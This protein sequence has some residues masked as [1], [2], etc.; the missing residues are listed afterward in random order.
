MSVQRQ[1]AQDKDIDFY[2]TYVNI[3]HRL[4]SFIDES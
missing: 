3:E 1:A 4:P 2:A